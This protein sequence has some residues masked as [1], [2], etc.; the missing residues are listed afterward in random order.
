[1]KEEE[2]EQKEE[3]T[4]S[5]FHQI[6]KCST[7][8]FC[9]LWSFSFPFKMWIKQSCQKTYA[10]VSNISLIP[11]TE[12]SLRVLTDSARGNGAG[13]LGFYLEFSWSWGVDTGVVAWGGPLMG[14][15]G[16]SVVLENRGIRPSCQFGYC[17]IPLWALILLGF[18][19]IRV[20]MSQ[21]LI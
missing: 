2:W 20:G 5:A 13:C 12:S 16:I 18:T 21:Y 10:F 8:L 11:E 4:R 19:A 9:T 14:C 6:L 15:K 17:P 7:N 1:M 3:G